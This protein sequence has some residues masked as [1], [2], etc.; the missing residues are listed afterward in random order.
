MIEV[1]HEI[2][3]EEYDKAQKQGPY[4]IIPDGIKMGYGAYCAGVYEEDGKYFIRYDQGSS[5]D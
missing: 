4:S 2:S 5:C 1:R 3:K